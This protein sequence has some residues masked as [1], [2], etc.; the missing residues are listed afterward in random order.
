[1]AGADAALMLDNYGFASELNGT[2]IFM[3]KDGIIYT[4]HADACLHGITR[5][6]NIW[7]E[8]TILLVSKKTFL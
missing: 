1:M 6:L 8:K 5:E 4:P 2:N 3:V 7:L